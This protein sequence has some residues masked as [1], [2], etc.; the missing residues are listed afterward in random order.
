M[1]EIKG[2]TVHV[3]KHLIV[4]NLDLQVD[5][6]QA[7]ALMGENGAGKTTVLRALAGDMACDFESFCLG[8]E[9]VDPASLAYP[10]RVFSLVDDY[11]WLSDA[12]VG[13]HFE[14]LARQHAGRTHDP[15]TQLGVAHLVDRLPF[16]M[17]SG[18]KRRCL[19]A[20]ALARPWD[21]LIVDEPESRLDHKT[22]KTIGD[23]FADFLSAG[24]SIVMATHSPELTQRLECATVDLD[25][26]SC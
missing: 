10:E 8:G 20:T 22:V 21:V 13:E 3:D 19:L 9:T 4:D 1:L 17:S 5:S 11:P 24:K 6:G 26:V 7:V 14:L 23:I 25:Q 18:Q 15:L 2:L 12:T 16:Q